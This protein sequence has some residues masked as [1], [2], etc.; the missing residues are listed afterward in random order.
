[1]G[2]NRTFFRK[3]KLLLD[4]IISGLKAKNIVQNLE[5]VASFSSGLISYRGRFKD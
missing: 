3:E 1:M 5:R 2:T 4:Q